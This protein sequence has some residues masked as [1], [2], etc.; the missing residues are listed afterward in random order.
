MYKVAH[1]IG[2]IQDGGAETLVKDYALLLDKSKFNVLI[3]ILRR[4]PDT[5]NDKILSQTGTRIIPLCTSNFILMKVI[6]KLNY[7][8]YI[9]LKLYLV[10]KKEKVEVLHIHMALLHYV[11]KISGK[12]KNIKLFYTCHTEPKRILDGEKK[13]ELKAAR[14]LIKNNNLQ[15]IALHKG[16]KEEINSMF[17]IDNT[18]VIRNGVDFNKYHVVK[19]KNEIRKDLGIPENAF[20]IGHVGRFHPVK[21]HDFLV[22]VFNAVY[23][24]NSAA[25][26]L[27]VGSGELKAHIQNKL[28]SCGLNGKYLILSHRSDVPVL[29][30]AMD[31]F[32]FPS[33]LEGFGIVM[34]E[35]QVSGL[36]C[37][38]SDTVPR[39]V[40]QTEN[41]LS[42]SLSDSPES[43]AEVILNPKIKGNAKGNLE[44]Y[45]MNKEIKNLEELYL[46]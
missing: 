7:W 33:L 41:A 40:F 19:T 22:E 46:K 44:N 39:E 24:K 32:V 36:R 45:N 11:K 29:M 34:I 16:M 2:S 18:V 23:K 20:V 21:N 5:A 1:F 4:S 31:V 37:I 17:G 28:D 38:A 30:K 42:L 26:L 6:Q 35:A 9:P 13:Y 10:L 8:W 12:I 25:F 15:M 14:Y 3:I 43:W 27:L